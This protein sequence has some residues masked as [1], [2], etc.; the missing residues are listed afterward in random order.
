MP[1]IHYALIDVGKARVT[2]VVFSQEAIDALP[3]DRVATGLMV[4][5]I[6]E[7]PPTVEGK[8]NVLFVNPDTKEMWWEQNDRPLSSIEQMRKDLDQLIIYLLEG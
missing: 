2:S 6:P 3:E 4:E 7:A 8:T 5:A 1:L